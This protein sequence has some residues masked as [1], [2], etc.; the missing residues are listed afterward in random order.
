M[1]GNAH[2]WPWKSTAKAARA[3]VAR[4]REPADLLLLARSAQAAGDAAALEEARELAR[5]IGMQDR[6]LSML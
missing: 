2:G 4:Q 3:N 5:R 6:R 1:S